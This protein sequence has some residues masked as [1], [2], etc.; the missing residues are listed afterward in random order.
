V[1]FDRH[2]RVKLLEHGADDVLA[3]PVDER[4]LVARVQAALARQRDVDQRLSELA[5]VRDHFAWTG[6]PTRA[7]PRA[8]PPRAGRA[9]AP[10]EHHRG[11]RGPA[12][13]LAALEVGAPLTR[14]YGS[15]TR[16]W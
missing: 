14:G 6:S 8:L 12:H 3:K 15:T 13:H 11:D 4:E 10:E 7:A 2:D 9:R 5:R 16:A 1:G